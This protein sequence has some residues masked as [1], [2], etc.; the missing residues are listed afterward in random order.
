MEYYFPKE[1]SW[2]ASTEVS[3]FRVFERSGIAMEKLQCSSEANPKEIT[4]TSS[5]QNVYST[6]LQRGVT[7][8]SIR[9]S[10]ENR[11]N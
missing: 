10:N 1:P 3:H 7:Q 6:V 5:N 9:E 4:F 2:F 8:I 11:S